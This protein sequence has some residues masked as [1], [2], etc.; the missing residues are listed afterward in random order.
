MTMLQRLGLIALSCFA[1]GGCAV[2]LLP[3]VLIPP[4][5]GTVG[6]GGLAAVAC[7][8]DPQCETPKSRC[9]DAAGKN[10]EVTEAADISIP[11][12]EG[13]VVSY[14]PAYW[15]SEF[16]SQ[17]GA[18]NA[19][20]SEAPVGTFAITDKSARFV[21]ARGAEGVHIPLAGVQNVELQHNVTTDAPRQMTVESCFGRMDRFTFGQPQQPNRLDT[22][23]TRAAAAE[24]RT[25][26]AA[27][28]APARGKPAGP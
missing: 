17:V 22:E 9:T 13:K 19:R 2:G 4:I 5:A 27:L 18:R 26:V 23:A 24:M 6:V 15:Q 20:Q 10:I 7:T 12:D 8:D 25:R 11:A 3:A 14:T 28:R 1:V 21:P 16:V